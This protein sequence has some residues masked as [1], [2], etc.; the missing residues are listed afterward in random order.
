M[1]SF[2]IASSEFPQVS[3]VRQKG[4]L[5]INVLRNTIKQI[6]KTLIHAEEQRKILNVISTHIIDEYSIE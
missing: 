5:Y 1:V 3:K 4:N 2:H 6:L